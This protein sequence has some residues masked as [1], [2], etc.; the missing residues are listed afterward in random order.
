MWG[1]AARYEPRMAES[2][3]ERLLGRWAEAVGRARGWARP[4]P[5]GDGA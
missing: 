3:R 1:E 5:A 2:E 4:E